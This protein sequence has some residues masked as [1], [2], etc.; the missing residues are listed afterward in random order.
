LV[1]AY[2]L[3]GELRNV[4]DLSLVLAMIEREGLLEQVGWSAELFASPGGLR[5]PQVAV[6]REVETVVN[7]RAINRRH[8]IAGISGGVRVDPRKALDVRANVSDAKAPSPI[9]RSTDDAAED[10]WW[11]D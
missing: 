7:H 5:L 3:Y 9:R 8:I 2:P 4:F 10:V 6:P 1:E 11:W